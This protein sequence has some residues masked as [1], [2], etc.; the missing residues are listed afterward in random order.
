MAYQYIMNGKGKV[1]PR[2]FLT[3]HH[4]MEAYRGVELKLHSFFELGTRW[5]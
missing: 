1:A 2:L 5:R 3:E 4:A